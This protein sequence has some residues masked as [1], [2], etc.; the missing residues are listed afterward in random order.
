MA[1]DIK[2]LVSNNLFE[3]NDSILFHYGDAPGPKSRIPAMGAVTFLASRAGL[4]V[5]LEDLV[6]HCGLECLGQFSRFSENQYRVWCFVAD[7]AW[8]T[9]TRVTRYKK[10]WK[11]HRDLLQT[12]GINE[13]GEEFEFEDEKGT[14]YAGMVEVSGEALIKAIKLVRRHASCTIILSRRQEIACEKEV[15]GI[16]QSAFREGTTVPD[17]KINFLSLSIRLCTQGDASLRVWGFFDDLEA[18]VDLIANRGVVD[19]FAEFLD[20]SEN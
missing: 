2:I 7:G 11:Y 20:Y 10:L 14:R 18:S 1:I 16:F 19:Q 8:Q 13:V 9:P 4:Q 12:P 15:R 6:V 3:N 17:G 5:I